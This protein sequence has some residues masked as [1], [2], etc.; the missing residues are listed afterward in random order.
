[1]TIAKIVALLGAVA[2]ALALANGF[3]AGDI[4]AEGGALLAMPWG[5]VSLVDL[6]VGFVLF[7]GWIIY[8]ET[9]PASAV[10][11]VVLLM[12]LGFFAASIYVLLA[13]QGSGGSWPRFWMGKRATT[14]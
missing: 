3:L 5:I 1:M 4:A 10:A 7:C 11:W 2:M 14:Q 12:V 8:R 13:L 9:S 6:Y